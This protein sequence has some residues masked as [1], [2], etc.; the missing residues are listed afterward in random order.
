MLLAIETSCD[1]TGVA[2]FPPHSLQPAAELLA[3]QTRLHKD[4]GGVVPELAARE[5]IVN[6]PEL[7]CRVLADTGAGIKDLSAVAV[8]C[9]PGLQGCLLVGV[10]Y[11]KALAFSR[12][13]PLIPIHHIEAHLAAGELLPEE[14]RPKYP[15]LALVVSGGHTMLIHVAG[16]RNYRTVAETRDDAAGEAFDKIATVLGLPY[17]GGPSLAAAAERGDPQAF[18]FPI[19]VPADRGSFSFS[20]LKT[21]VARAVAAVPEAERTPSFVEDAA[22]SAERAIVAA[23]TGKSAA[24]CLELQPASFLLTGG[25]AANKE[26]RRSLSAAMAEQGVPFC[27]PDRKWCTDNAAMVGVLAQRMIEARFADYAA[28][29]AAP[30][31]LGPDAAWDVGARARWPIE[32]AAG[33]YLDSHGNE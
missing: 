21:A 6:L 20:G 12:G 26:L 8:T 17:P 5:H 13:I 23:L 24:A 33:R 16:F 18:G 30:S 25:V 19:G 14:Q 27:V 3:S 22:A 1:E 31:G 11:A 28:W 7:T 2:L 15:C 4:Y 9:G 32:E 29:P 10:S